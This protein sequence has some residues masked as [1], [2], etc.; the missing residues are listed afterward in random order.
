MR[1]CRY[2]RDLI[3]GL[4]QQLSKTL[5][6]GLIDNHML[7]LIFDMVKWG[8]DAYNHTSTEKERATQE[9]NGRSP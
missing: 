6:V 3:S 5:S 1:K 7:L 2:R 8:G 4:S 9:G